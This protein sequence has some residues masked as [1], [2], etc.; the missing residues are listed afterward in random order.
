MTLPL[1]HRT[2]PPGQDGLESVKKTL[3]VA[4]VGTGLPARRPPMQPR[5]K[6]ST[7]P[8]YVIDDGPRNETPGDADCGIAGFGFDRPDRY[9]PVPQPGRAPS[10]GRGANPRR[11]RA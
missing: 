7:Q 5:P 6:T 3:Q 4:W 1:D 8:G 11:H 10:G 2:L 9:V